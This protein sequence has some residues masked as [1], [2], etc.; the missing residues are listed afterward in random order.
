MTKLFYGSYVICASLAL[1]QLIIYGLAYLSGEIAIYDN[2]VNFICGFSS[3][4]LLASVLSWQPI[5]II[6]TLTFTVSTVNMY[7]WEMSV[8]PIDLT[9]MSFSNVLINGLLFLIF[10]IVPIVGFV[11]GASLLRQHVGHNE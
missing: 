10:I 6:T 4:V 3:F 1:L 8:H 7:V 2:I 5:R 9:R 11:S